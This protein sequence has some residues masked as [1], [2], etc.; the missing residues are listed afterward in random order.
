MLLLYDCHI[1]EDEVEGTCSVHGENYKFIGLLT[2]AEK[3][4]RRNP[5][6]RRAVIRG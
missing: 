6:A 3:R 5:S 1:R 4:E 2:F